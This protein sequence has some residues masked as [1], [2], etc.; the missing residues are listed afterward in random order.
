MSGGLENDGAKLAQRADEFGGE[1]AHGFDALHLRVERGGGFEFKS[2]P[3][4]G[5]AGC[6]G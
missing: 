2:R 5:R 6:G 1:G 4:P 3:R